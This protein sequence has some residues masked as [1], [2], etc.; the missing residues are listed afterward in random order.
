MAMS[1]TERLI[2]TP[3]DTAGDIISARPRRQLRYISVSDQ[4]LSEGRFITEEE[5]LSFFERLRRKVRGEEIKVVQVENPLEDFPHDEEFAAFM[6][7]LGTESVLYERTTLVLNGDNLDFLAVRWNGRFKASEIEYEYEGLEKA[8]IIL[9]GHPVYFDAL[10]AFLALPNTEIVFLPGNHDQQIIWPDVQ[11]LLAW[12]IAGNDFARRARVIF[13]E[14]DEH[15]PGSFRFERDG[16][17]F[18]HGNNADPIN[19]TP[20]KCIRQPRFGRGKGLPYMEMNFGARWA[21]AVNQMKLRNAHIGRNHYAEGSHVWIYALL[22]SWGWCRIAAWWFLV[23]VFRLIIP[24]WTEGWFRRIR[25][26]STVLLSTIWEDKGA[27][28]RWVDRIRRAHAHVKV[29]IHGHTHAAARRTE[30]VEDGSKRTVTDINSGTWIRMIRMLWP[31]F[32]RTWTSFRWLEVAVRAFQHFLKTGK[33]S[34]ARK[35]IRVTWMITVAT[36]LTLFVL[37]R[38]P[39][40]HYVLFWNVEPNDFRWPIG[41]LLVFAL[42]SAIISVFA[43]KPEEE[44]FRKLTFADISYDVIETAAEDGTTTRAFDGLRADCM[45]WI[46]QE[47][48]VRECVC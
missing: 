20:P 44:P 19:A 13:V 37:T 7:R 10:A 12:R 4:H 1:V 21:E 25:L 43:V 38:F 45:E 11:R 34:Y 42:I 18:E 2:D 31:T 32:Q 48:T 33:I 6:A 28:D 41:I 27:T 39:G 35:T 46:P 14:E 17:F 30:V 24:F 5:S 8:R 22:H 40:E 47:A 9:E 16:L 23:T 36:A 3:S 15:E 29:I 26:V